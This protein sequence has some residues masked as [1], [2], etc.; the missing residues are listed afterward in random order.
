MS[1]WSVLELEENASLKEIK[2]SYAKKLKHNKP[3]ENPEGFQRLNTAYQQACKIAKQKA[4]QQTY[5]AEHA[6]LASL[7]QPTPETT[8]ASN[9][10]PLI[11]KEVSLQEMFS[12]EHE[13]TQDDPVGK[14]STVPLIERE[15]S[16]DDNEKL[17]PPPYTEDDLIHDVDELMESD[18]I[19]DL[20]KW[21]AL[22]DSQLLYEIR[23]RGWFTLRLFYLVSKK[24]AENEENHLSHETLVFLNE[25]MMWTNQTDRLEAHFD[26]EEIERVKNH[27]KPKP[28]PKLKEQQQ[29]FKEIHKTEKERITDS[30][31]QHAS[32]FKRFA[33]FVIDILIFSVGLNIIWKINDAI[34]DSTKLLSEN[35][36]WVFIIWLLILFPL[37]ESLIQATPGKFLV[38]IKVVT[39][40]GKKLNILHAFLRFILCIINLAAIKITLLINSITFDGRFLHDRLSSSKV[41]DRSQND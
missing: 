30:R 26:F 37:M 24:I 9:P 25:K 14:P 4:R 32:I 27:L 5:E 2:K 7:E 31:K 39:E 38:G 19:N 6:E 36:F 22:L 35:V 17:E 16:R 11:E 23:F 41:V 28:K 12:P 10:T 33:A 29:T 1:C 34:P 3:D 13:E 8:T 20:S 15:L 18:H 21:E 40:K